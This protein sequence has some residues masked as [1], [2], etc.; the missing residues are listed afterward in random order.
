MRRFA[1]VFLFLCLALATPWVRAQVPQA[2]APAIAWAYGEKLHLAGVPNA[3]KISDQ[4]FRG[5]QPRGGGLEQLKKVGITTIVDLR[6]EDSSAREREKREA[7]ALGIHF[8]SIPVSGWSAPSRDQVAQF[9][10]LF[11]EKSARVFVHCRFGEDRTGVFV[12]IYRMAIEKWPV[13]AAV[14]EMY[15]FGYNGFWHR[16]MSAYVRKFPALLSST[17]AFAASGGANASAPVAAHN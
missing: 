8:V 15:F 12:A 3:G 1:V 7:E 5:A 6:S 10:S 11:G 2:G 16:A 14:K 4:L 13:D 9:L 17:A